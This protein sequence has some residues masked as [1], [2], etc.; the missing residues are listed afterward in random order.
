MNQITYGLVVYHQ[1]IGEEPVFHIVQRRDTLAYIEF[2]RGH[3]SENKLETFFS[4]M[5]NEEKL[6][7]ISHKFEDLWI[8]LFP[9]KGTFPEMFY[10]SKTLFDYYNSIGILQ[11]TYQNTIDKSIELE[12]SI[13][14]GRKKSEKEVNLICAQREYR[15]ETKNKCYLEFVDLPPIDCF[16]PTPNDK[17]VF[18]I[19]RSKFRP[20]PVYTSEERSFIQRDYV[21]D[22]TNDIK[23]MTIKECESL[24]SEKYIELLKQV[25]DSIKKNITFLPLKDIV[26]KYN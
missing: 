19:A 9:N 15:E 26:L 16:Y 22:E 20:Q 8:D 13:P 14:K 18:Y 25:N 6:R 12:W 2:I 24:L 5:T 17:I 10:K 1:N 11:K 23:W 21:S 4:N 7:I 3:V